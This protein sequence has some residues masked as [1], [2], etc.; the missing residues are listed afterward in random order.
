M[1]VEKSGRASPESLPATMHAIPSMG[2]I[3]A[4][5]YMLTASPNGEIDKF[6]LGIM[7]TEIQVL[8]AM[9]RMLTE[10][11]VQQIAGTAPIPRLS[12]PG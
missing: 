12:V 3:P 8:S 4:P 9:V 6:D 1:Q 5:D 10:L 2:P 7:Y 11:S